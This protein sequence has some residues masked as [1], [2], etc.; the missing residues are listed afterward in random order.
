ML[1]W[2]VLVVVYRLRVWG[3]ERVP[4]AVVNGKPQ[5]FIIAL[6]H[7][8]HFDP[9]LAGKATPK[10]HLSFI[11]RATLFV[12]PVFGWAIKALGAFPINQKAADTQAIRET[13]AQLEMG[14][15]VLIFPEG[16]RTPTGA[17][18]PVKR[19]VWLLIS[20]SKCPVLPVA[21]EGAFDAW[22]RKASFPRLIGQRIA[23]NV[24][25]PIAAETLLAMGPQAGLAHLAQTIETLRLE[26][27][28]KFAA[29]GHR[30]TT[31][32]MSTQDL[33]ADG[34]VPEVKPAIPKPV[35]SKPVGA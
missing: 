12:N 14:R 21:I 8:S 9:V 1:F 31:K 29:S 25:E 28:D 18:H 5:P 33:D 2:F 20:R 11:A 3:R 34:F 23:L 32:P 17:I 26:L 4:A 22:P 7:Q 6:N 15:A 13:L 10:R 16:S 24:G 27:V 30:V 35:E 19:G